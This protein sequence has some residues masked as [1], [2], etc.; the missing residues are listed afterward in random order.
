ML[1]HNALVN[2]SRTPSTGRV[3]VYEVQGLRQNDETDR[4][5][6]QVRQ[7]THTHTHTHKVPDGRMNAEM[8]RILRL[9]GTIV[10]IQPLNAEPADA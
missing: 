6:Y 9:G 5:N 8:Q 10:N 3:F 1:A 2:S 4:Q 7:S